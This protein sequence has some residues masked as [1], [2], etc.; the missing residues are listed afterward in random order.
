MHLPSP[1]AKG[2]QACCS[3]RSGLAAPALVGVAAA[4]LPLVAALLLQMCRRPP[5]P[6]FT[7]WVSLTL[8]C[9]RLTGVADTHTGFPV[10][11]VQALIR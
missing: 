7:S 8:T 9:L 11:I 3:S 4:A 2:M 5:R 6:P 1:L 10:T